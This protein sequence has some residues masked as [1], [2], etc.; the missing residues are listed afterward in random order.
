MV[1]LT[2]L[3]GVALWVTLDLDNPRGGLIQLSD[4]PLEALQFDQ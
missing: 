3:I 2:V 4:A 1:S